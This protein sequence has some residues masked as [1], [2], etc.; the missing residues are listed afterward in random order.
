MSHLLTIS[1][2]S[3]S[4]SVAWELNDWEA[5]YPALFIQTPPPSSPSLPPK[6]SLPV[7][8][9]KTCPAFANVTWYSL[10]SIPFE[11]KSPATPSSLTPSVYDQEIEFPLIISFLFFQLT[12]FVVFGLSL[13]LPLPSTQDFHNGKAE[14]IYSSDSSEVPSASK[15]LK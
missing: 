5:I 6:K 10:N 3:I 1:V 7:T 11:S 4:T 13:D 9:L 2:T 15:S 14:S 8:L 12:P